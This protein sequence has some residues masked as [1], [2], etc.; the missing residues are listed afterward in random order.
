MVIREL[1]KLN[2][3]NFIHHRVCLKITNSAQYVF[4]AA[5]QFVNIIVKG[6]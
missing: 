1:K 2:A 3:F 4:I 5:T 6:E